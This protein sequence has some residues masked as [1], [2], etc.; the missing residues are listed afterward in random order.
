MLNKIFFTAIVV[1][2]GTMLSCNMNETPQLGSASVDKVLK[3]ITLEEK[4][5]LFVGTGMAGF[6]GD[7]AMCAVVETIFTRRENYHAKPGSK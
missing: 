2:A 7:A 1:V 5:Q 4:V 6:S 3:A